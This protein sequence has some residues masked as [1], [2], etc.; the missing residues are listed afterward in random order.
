[1]ATQRPLYAVMQAKSCKGGI[2]HACKAS[3]G[4]WM[5]RLSPISSETGVSLVSQ[6]ELV[7]HRRGKGVSS[8]STAPAMIGEQVV[9][10][11]NTGLLRTRFVLH[12]SFMPLLQSVG[13]MCER[14]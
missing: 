4:V 6:F 10:A 13:A 11:A 14:H 3:L 9:R 2:A 8:V 7:G 5:P 1:M 12:G